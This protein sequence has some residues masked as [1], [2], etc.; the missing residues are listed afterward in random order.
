MGL[1]S[2]GDEI[3]STYRYDL[4][5][6]ELY[7]YRNYI[8]PEYGPWEAWYAWYPVRRIIAVSFRPDRTIHKLEW[9]T[10]L[11]RRRVSSRYFFSS[12]DRDRK[13]WEYTTMLEILRWG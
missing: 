1:S 10:N 13:H 12:E 7:R 8:D 9:L 3:G 2:I 6:N 11:M 5:V 4:P